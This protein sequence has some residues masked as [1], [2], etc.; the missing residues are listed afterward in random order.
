VT[1]EGEGSHAGGAAAPGATSARSPEGALDPFRAL[2]EMFRLMMSGGA[3]APERP[4]APGAI[5]APPGP[6]APA[7][8]LVGQ[9][10]GAFMASGLRY[11]SRLAEIWMR[12]M[13]ALIGAA[14]R[15]PDGGAGGAAAALR[16]DLRAALHE[17]AELPCQESRRLQAELDRIVSGGAAPAPEPEAPYWRRWDAKP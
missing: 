16:D 12:T 1:D 2:E 7:L 4:A 14:A 17:L 8:G 15:P 13:P 11:W 9:V 6:A 3:S 10:G 5:G